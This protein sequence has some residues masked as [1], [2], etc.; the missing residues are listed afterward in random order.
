VAIQAVAA[1]W[2][3]D[4]VGTK[5]AERYNLPPWMAK[6]FKKKSAKSEAKRWTRN[7]ILFLLLMLLLGS[8]LIIPT[9]DTTAQLSPTTQEELATI[10]ASQREIIASVSIATQVPQTILEGVSYTAS[11]FGT[12]AITIAPAVESAISA[13]T[14]SAS[15]GAFDSIS[16]LQDLQ[17]IW[18]ASAP[19]EES[20]VTAA[21]SEGLSLG[22]V[23]SEVGSI[24]TDALGVLAFADY[25]ASVGATTST[26]NVVS[27]A[28]ARGASILGLYLELKGNQAASQAGISYASLYQDPYSPQNIGIWRNIVDSLPLT[29]P[30][31]NSCFNGSNSAPI[32]TI[33]QCGS[34]TPMPSQQSSTTPP[35]VQLASWAS[36]SNE[37]F[38]MAQY[39]AGVQ[40]VNPFAVS[41]SSFSGTVPI[42]NPTY[43]Q[44]YQDAAKQ[45]CP[46]MPWELVAAVAQQ[47]TS[48]NPNDIN[49]S[50]GLPISATNSS[51]Q[52][53]MQIAPATFNEYQQQVAQYVGKDHGVVPMTVVDP[54]DSI[55][56]A[57]QILCSDG[58]GS[59]NVYQA[60]E[61]YNCGNPNNCPSGWSYGKDVLGYLQLFQT[62]V[63]SGNAVNSPIILSAINYARQQVIDKVPYVWGGTSVSGFDC[64]GLVQAAY[65][66]AGVQLPRVAQDQFNATIPTQTLQPGD[67]VFF[68]TT[69]KTIDHVG[70]Y[71]GMDPSNP[72][73]AQMINAPTTGMDVQ[74]MDFTAN[75][76]AAWDSANGLY[77]MGAHQ[78][79]LP[80]SAP[81]SAQ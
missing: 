52:G 63:A 3:I 39:L 26:T 8:C 1:K 13:E 47:E 55:Y 33:Y 78:V 50:T 62:E 56:V 69:T 38:T 25:K 59:N 31:S 35:P 49:T 23:A 67:L 7:F 76:G 21:A 65:G 20:L 37:A 46:A 5:V 42:I 44:V 71:V 6:R 11:D 77:Y 60:L 18:S 4:K 9:L 32:D 81:S 16:T 24:A 70:I 53:Y 22:A 51:G 57:T 2:A 43:Y 27:P 17:Q 72:S 66:Q 12:S 45:V 64:S 40:G 14:S 73:L 61:D 15:A 41:T 54:V 30:V 68:G 19:M 48:Q 75:I 29:P 58:A 36:V 80:A 79:I 10:P 34:I 28:Y 74:Y